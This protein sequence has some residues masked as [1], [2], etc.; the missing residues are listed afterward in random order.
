M[1]GTFNGVNFG[2]LSEDQW[3]LQY[4]FLTIRFKKYVVLKV[5]ALLLVS[6]IIFILTFFFLLAKM[7]LFKTNMHCINASAPEK[8]FNF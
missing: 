3:V 5:K 8:I 2:S 1:N 7:R 6:R 4:F